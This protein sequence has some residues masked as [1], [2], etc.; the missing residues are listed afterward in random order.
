[1]TLKILITPAL[2]RSLPRRQAVPSI[3]AAF[4]SDD[5]DDKNEKITFC[6][7]RIAQIGFQLHSA[8]EGSQRFI[9]KEM[10]NYRKTFFRP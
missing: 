7:H 9:I 1:M 3:S 2:T 5:A 8:P 6:V 4:V 10:L